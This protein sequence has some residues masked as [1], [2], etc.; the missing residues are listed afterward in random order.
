MYQQ[1]FYQVELYFG[2]AVCRNPEI[3][4]KKKKEKKKKNYEYFQKNCQSKTVYFPIKYKTQP[5]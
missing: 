4:M 2:Y 5:T 1:I 3:F